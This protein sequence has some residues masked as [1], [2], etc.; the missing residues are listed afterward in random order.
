MKIYYYLLILLPLLNLNP[1]KAKTPLKSSINQATCKSKHNIA[2]EISPKLQLIICDKEA[3]LIS[4]KKEMRKTA[5]EIN[6]EDPSEHRANQVK[7][8]ATS[9]PIVNSHSFI[10]TSGADY[11]DGA[12]CS[13]FLTIYEDHIIAGPNFCV[14][15]EGIDRSFKVQKKGKFIQVAI[16]T[17]E[18]VEIGT[19]IK[20]KF[21]ESEAW[22]WKNNSWVKTFEL[23]NE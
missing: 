3:I 7:L 5:V 18:E 20:S 11:G 2:K 17:T 19:K 6:W 13:Q 9:T 23:K 22:T 21:T 1:V 15:G 10:L 8:E 12:N 16:I 14:A 4:E